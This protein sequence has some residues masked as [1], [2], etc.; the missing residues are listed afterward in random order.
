MQDHFKKSMDLYKR[1]LEDGIAKECARNVLPMCTPTRMYMTGN[2]R[3]WI[4]YIELRTGNGTQKEHKDIADAIKKIFVCEFPVIARA[5]DWCK[6]E[7]FCEEE[8]TDVQ[9]C[10]MIRP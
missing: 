5:L 2:I 4:H 1:M 9:P 7:C 10:I 3:N 8:Y 6:D